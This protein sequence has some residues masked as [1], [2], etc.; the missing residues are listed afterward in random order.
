MKQQL[1]GL[2]KSPVTSR[3]LGGQVRLYDVQWDSDGETLV[4]MEGRGKQGVIVAQRG[5]DAPRDLN[6]DHSAGGGV[7]YGGGDF[8]VHN[9]WVYF[10][11]PKGRLYR[12]PVTGG[13]PQPI[14]PSVD[15]VASPQVSPDGRWIAYIYTLE[16]ED[17]IA[18]VDVEG[19]HWPRQLIVGPDFEMQPVWHPAGDWLAYITW[20]QPKMPWDE[21]LLHL[22]RISR[23]TEGWPVVESSQVIAGGDNVAIFQ[24]E[25]SPDGRYLSYVSDVEDQ[26]QLFLLELAT[27]EVTQLTTAKADH[28][29]PAWV[30]GTRRYGWTADSRTIYSLRNTEGFTTVWRIDVASREVSP[31][32][33]LDA[34]THFDQIS[35]S[36]SG[37]VAAVGASGIQ[38]DRI[39]TISPDA[40]TARIY[41]RSGAENI[42]AEALSVPRPVT[43]TG[44]DGETVYGIYYPPA[45]A[46][47][48]GAGLPPLIVDVH[49]GP[50]GQARALFDGDAQ[51]FATRG[52]AM[53]LVNYR[54]SSGFGKAYI[55]KL[56]GA[57]GVYDV[58][59]AASGAQAMVAQGLANPN[60]L[61]IKGGSA[62][63]FTVLQ[64]LIEK[65]GFYKAGVCLYGVADQFSLV[66]DS[67]FKFETYYSYGLLGVLHE[68]VDLYRARSPRFHAD[69]IQDP[70][71][72]FQGDEDKVVQQ[73]Q[74]DTIVAALKASG[75]AH[76]Y[77]V[78]EGEGHGFRKPENIER[79]YDLTLD[80]LNRYVILG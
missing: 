80:F 34:Y 64:S 22:A 76:E 56:N 35:V 2:W 30:Q 74:S 77:Y 12:V 3:A 45:S 29:A 20:N 31:V 49:G 79:Y 57:W 24:P 41:R 28:G 69:K 51:F 1:Y 18:V 72:L 5:L 15:G 63:G 61:V 40:P 73:S 66:L 43:W 10:A 38:T 62:G 70:L 48:E 46:V 7:G 47:Y 16:N 26:N 25:F 21:T 19:K 13:L 27:G 32:E 44:H 54:G 39:L 42:P 17:G 59:D 65:P 36:G 60:K 6:P 33:G 4:W 53:L 37:A 23:D 8:T 75:A 50:T 52:Y 11:G 78:F 55:N 14:T 68:S 9:S 58:E 67:T 71:I